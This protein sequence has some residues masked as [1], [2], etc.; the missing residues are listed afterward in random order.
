VEVLCRIPVNILDRLISVFGGYGFALA[1]TALTTRI[2]RKKN[3]VEQRREAGP[4]SKLFH[5]PRR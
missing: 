2:G 3:P 5:V 4:G 1:L